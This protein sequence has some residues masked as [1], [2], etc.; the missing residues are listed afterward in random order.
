MPLVGGWIDI[1]AHFYPPEADEVRQRRLALMRKACWCTE[2]V[3]TWSLEPVLAYMDRTGIAMQMLSNIPKTVDALQTSN[4]YGA[5]LAR[6]YPT[7]FGFLA[8][9]P[10]DEPGA[11]LDEIRRADAL[12][13]DGYAVTCR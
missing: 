13:P 1:H 3:P 8:A 7:R 11:A 9:L 10:T 6:E 5:S 12:D 4:D 2:S